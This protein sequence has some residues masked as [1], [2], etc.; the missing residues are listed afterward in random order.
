MDF[1]FDIFTLA[2]V[3]YYVF[4]K[5]H[6]PFGDTQKARVSGIE[7]NRINFNPQQL[8]ADVVEDAVRVFNML[9]AMLNVE[10]KLRPTATQVLA[11]PFFKNS[12][13]DDQSW[14]FEGK[15]QIIK[16]LMV[17]SFLYI[18]FVL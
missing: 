6:H 12:T 8:V 14:E 10:S 18:Y 9:Q 4:T 15:S 16:C 11:H 13:P 1:P 2:C 3:I 5:G 7:N 17:F